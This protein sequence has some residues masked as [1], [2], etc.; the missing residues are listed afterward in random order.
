M[1]EKAIQR[2]GGELLN[3]RLTGSVKATGALLVIHND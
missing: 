3:R 1:A 2:H